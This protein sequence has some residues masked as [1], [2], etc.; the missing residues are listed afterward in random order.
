[1]LLDPVDILLR[2]VTDAVFFQKL[3]RGIDSFLKRRYVSG[4]SRFE[5]RLIQR[6]HRIDIGTLFLA[7]GTYDE[8]ARDPAVISAYLGGDDE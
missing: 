8:V 2:D 3:F 4:F 1:L 7:E 5:N 6:I